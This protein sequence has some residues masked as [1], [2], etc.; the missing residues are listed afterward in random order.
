MTYAL[1]N[2]IWDPD[3]KA[4]QLWQWTMPKQLKPVKVEG[5]SLKGFVEK[6][7]SKCRKKSDEKLNTQAPS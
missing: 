1:Y 3:L 4:F 6:R 5:K 7:K 2:L